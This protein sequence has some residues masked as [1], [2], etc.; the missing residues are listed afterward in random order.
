MMMM[1]IVV[2]K[3]C[4]YI[5]LLYTDIR[6]DGTEIFCVNLATGSW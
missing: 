5:L 6:N 2:V 3:S 4:S 1:I